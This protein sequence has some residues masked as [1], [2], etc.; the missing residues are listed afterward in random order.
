[1]AEHPI[2]YIPAC[3]PN[4]PAKTDV[5]PTTQRSRAGMIGGDGSPAAIPAWRP[6]GEPVAKVPALAQVPRA[7]L[8][9]DLRAAQI[10]GAH[11][12]RHG[13]RGVPG[14]SPIL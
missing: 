10:V 3:Q 12:Q 2:P 9:V 8:E 5:T 4:E 6:V 13:E 14:V 7:D 11:P 1:M